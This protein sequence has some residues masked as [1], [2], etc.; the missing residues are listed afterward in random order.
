MIKLLYLGD[1]VCNTGF[2]QVSRN[3]VDQL[4]KTGEYEIDVVGIN[5]NGDPFDTELWKGTVYPA[6]PGGMVKP[7]YD[8]VYGRQRFI[9]MLGT[10]EYDAAMILQ[11]SFVVKDFAKPLRET[12]NGVNTA[13]VYYYPVDS[14]MEQDWVTGVI[15]IM[16]FPVVYTEFGRRE[17]LERAPKLEKKLGVIYHGNNFGE[18]NYLPDRG[19]VAKARQEFFKGKA[20]GRFLI[21]NVA[22]NQIRKDILHSL[23]TI[24]ELR[25]TKPE[26][27]LYLH[28]SDQDQ[29][30]VVTSY[31]E[32]LGLVREQDYI[33]PFV[34]NKGAGIEVVNLLYNFS[35]L[36]LS[37]THG[38]GWGLPIT[39]AFATK[40]PVVAPN[41]TSLTEI[42]ADNRA[43]LVDC[44][45]YHTYAY[46]D[47]CRV[48][49]VINHKQAASLIAKYMDGKLKVDTEGAHEWLKQ[50]S[51]EN[52]GQ[53]WHEILQQAAQLSY[54][55]RNTP[56]FSAS[57]SKPNKKRKQERQN[58]RRGRG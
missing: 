15:D 54:N 26:A 1:Y 25:K 32:Q 35:D 46:A 22:R 38:E 20:D 31:A 36:L 29:G 50:Y 17:T 13:L 41:N 6:R 57:K 51:W 28:M 18:F 49:P 47:N 33:V 37:T 2:G 45:D 7:P 21:T 53:A 56:D 12:A 34:F 10:G 40:T 24:K 19:A 43:I 5:Y 9:D 39:E 42:G 44:S 23:L 58:R 52:I 48:R 8:D 27:L 3:I 14:Q 4:I 30:G 55:R 11:D 16:D